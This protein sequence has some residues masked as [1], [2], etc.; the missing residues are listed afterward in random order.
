MS[1]S[2]DNKN[3]IQSAIKRKGALRKKAAKEG[4]ITQKGTI[5]KQ[6][7]KKQTHS[8]NERLQREARLA[9]TFARLRRLKKLH[10]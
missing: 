10:K 7:L 3:W 2:N 4:A 8:S 6:W 1:S 9:E 5:N